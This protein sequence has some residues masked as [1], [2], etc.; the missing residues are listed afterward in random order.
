MDVPIRSRTS[1]YRFSAHS[2]G[3]PAHRHSF[4]AASTTRISLFFDHVVAF[5]MQQSIAAG[6]TR[7]LFGPAHPR[8]AS[9][10][11]GWQS[12]RHVEAACA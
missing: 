3:S 6:D 8:L 9:R 4:E 7:P 5:F 11:F 12:G 10:R 1:L 2:N